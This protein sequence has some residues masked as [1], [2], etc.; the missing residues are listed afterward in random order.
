MKGVLGEPEQTEGLCGQEM[1]IEHFI[2]PKA[3]EH[4]CCSTLGEWDS[5]ATLAKCACFRDLTNS[6]T[7]HQK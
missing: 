3:Y 4:L 6:S 7:N 2:R 1:R 5:S